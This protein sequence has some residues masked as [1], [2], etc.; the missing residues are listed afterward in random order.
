MR[1]HCPSIILSATEALRTAKLD[2]DF[3]RLDAEAFGGCPSQ[4]FDTAVMEKI[5]KGVVYLLIADGAISG[6]G[7]H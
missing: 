3:L 4:P 6:P 5:D 7:A 1:L 2:L